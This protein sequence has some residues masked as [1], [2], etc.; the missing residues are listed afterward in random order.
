MNTQALDFCMQVSL[1]HASLQLKLD[2]ALGTWHGMG[3]DDF[4]LLRQ[5]AQAPGGRL[6]LADLVRPLGLRPS[7]VMRQLVPLEK[8][9]RIQ[10]EP[11]RYVLL[12][13][14]GRSQL[15]EATETAS[16]ICET[17]LRELGMPPLSAAHDLLVRLCRSPAL[18]L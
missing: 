15:A 7:A 18:E 9:G 4:M 10:R 3:L 16:A 13:P 1:G 17:A 5:L 11:G 8:T 6:P 12:R 14:A 2:D